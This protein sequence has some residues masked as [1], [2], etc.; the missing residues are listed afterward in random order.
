MEVVHPEGLE[1]AAV[2]QRG[3]DV[4][5]EPPIAQRL[6]E[7]Q[8]DVQRQVVEVPR[9]DPDAEQVVAPERGAD[10]RHDLLEQPEP[11]GGGPS[12]PVASPVDGRVQELVEQVALRRRHLETVA[13]GVAHPHGRTREV[14]DHALDLA[15]AHRAAPGSVAVQQVEPVGGG[16]PVLRLAEQSRLRVIAGVPDL[17]DVPAPQRLDRPDPFRDGPHEAVLADLRVLQRRP[18]TVVH[19]EGGRDDG[20]DAVL[21]E[22]SLEM[23]PGGVHGA[24]VVRVTAPDRG[25]HEAVRELHPVD[26]E[27]GE[28]R[29][30]LAHA[31]PRAR[32]R[33]NG[34]M[35][36]AVASGSSY[37]GKW[38]LPGR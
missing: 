13:P 2:R 27:R 15:E 5:A 21:G 8:A 3:V 30:R 19:R 32:S 9:R 38:P 14:L 34:M 28:D 6:R 24:V 22:P 16:E 12:V 29:V 26:G 37:I 36:A 25:A 31:A 7:R 18:P 33:R 23:R 1:P 35:A 11:V 20:A 4:V 17:H 10:G